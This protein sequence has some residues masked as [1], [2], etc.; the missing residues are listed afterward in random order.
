MARQLMRRLG[1]YLGRLPGFDKAGFDKRELVECVRAADACGYDS[2]WMPEAWERE[3]LTILTELALNTQRIHLGTGIINVF[4]RSPALIA[5]SAATLDEISGGRFRLGLG[6]SGARLIEDF[7]GLEY[8]NPL[9]RLK[10]SIHIIRALLA[11]ER[12]DFAGECFQLRRFKLGFKPLR[13]HIPIYVAALTPKSLRQLGET[14]DGW[15]PTHWPR[16]RLQAGIDE[17]RA[18][19]EGAER[20]S[21]QIEIAPFVNVVVS[22]DLARARNQA[23]LPLAYYLGGMGDFYHDALSRLG[24]AAEA[25]RIR[26]LW[27]AGRRKSAIAEVTDE[28]V[29]SIAICGPLETCRA[30][31]DEMHA[32]G[33][34][35]PLISI[36]AEG[37]TSEKCRLIEVLIK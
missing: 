23:R 12:V 1:L 26:E 10:E 24:F 7:H 8:A 37:N 22:E 27:Q 25:D 36:P 9:I 2:F 19:A 35:L 3:A 32:F 15:L 16:A 31:L 30:R 20:D 33:A 11:G 34:T 13:S 14:A 5:M 18:G 21:N 17:I 4:S 6:T 29:D 28:M